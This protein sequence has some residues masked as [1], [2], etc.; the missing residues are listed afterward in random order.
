[1]TVKIGAVVL[2]GGRSA[3]FGRDKLAEPIDGRP[4]LDHA[5]ECV[6]SLADEI[7][8]VLAPSDARALPS[9]VRTVHDPVAFEGPLAGLG[10]GLEALRSPIALIVG[11]DMPSLRTS[12]LAAL[13]ASRRDGDSVIAALRDGD[14]AR[15]LPIAVRV[16]DVAAAVDRLLERGERRLGAVLDELPTTVIE[17]SV[18][19]ALD[20]A[21]ATLRDVDIPADL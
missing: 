19:R 17:E 10:A 3:R 12:V 8:V 11:G 9:G 15:P 4:L 21:A 7:V 5:I 16:P 2:A 6:R 1:M 18:W 14:R 13:L 20:P